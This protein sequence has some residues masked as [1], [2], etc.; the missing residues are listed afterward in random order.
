MII[1]KIAEK[2][3]MK[4]ATVRK[5]F[6]T[7]ENIIFDHLSST[8]PTENTI[9]KLFD[10]LNIDCKYISEKEIIH[11]D[12]KEKIIVRNKIWGKAKLTRYYNRKLN[13]NLKSNNT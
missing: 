9:V 4:V 8:T 10:G 5:I 13:K 3:D 2:E 6:D 7:M 12:T 1:K 11:P